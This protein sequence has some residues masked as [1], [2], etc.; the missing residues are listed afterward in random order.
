MGRWFRCHCLWMRLCMTFV[1]SKKKD[2]RRGKYYKR[3]EGR[4][5]G[6]EEG[7]GRREGRVGKA[8]QTQQKRG[9]LACGS[10]NFLKISLGVVEAVHITYEQR[11]PTRYGNI[12]RWFSC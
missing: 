5:E 1:Q 12:Y 3:E 9:Y 11:R 8:K 2:K 10:T 6:R 4:G 7:R